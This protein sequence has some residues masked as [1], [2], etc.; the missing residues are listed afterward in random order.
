MIPKIMQDI[1]FMREGMFNF[2]HHRI[3]AIIDIGMI[4]AI[5]SLIEILN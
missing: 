3:Q 5:G 2:F 4:H 1:L